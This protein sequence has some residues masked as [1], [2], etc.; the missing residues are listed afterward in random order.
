M[1]NFVAS[2]YINFHCATE[3]ETVTD[4]VFRHKVLYVFSEYKVNC[5]ELKRMLK[6]INQKQPYQISWLIYS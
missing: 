1:L 6:Q 2:S 5:M 4:A 3:A